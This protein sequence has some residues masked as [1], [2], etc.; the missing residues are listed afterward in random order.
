[1]LHVYKKLWDYEPARQFVL[2]PI[3]I[4]Q[5]PS[6]EK[7][8]E[9]EQFE[10]LVD[11]IQDTIPHTSAADLAP[12]TPLLV[13]NFLHGW[14]SGTP[15]Q[16]L[17]ESYQ[18]ALTQA[19]LVC[20]QAGVVF[21]DLRPANI[22]WKENADSTVSIKLI[23]F[24]HVYTAGYAIDIDLVKAHSEDKFHRYDVSTYDNKKKHYFASVKTNYF[25]VNQI[26]AYLHEFADHDDD[27]AYTFGKFCK[28][29]WRVHCSGYIVMGTVVRTCVWITFSS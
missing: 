11:R 1:M 13:Y 16:D 7:S 28:S 15:R 23:D 12:F 4:T 19:V 9:K 22:M 21:T 25:A 8:K 27:D 18:N 5:L 6:K 2:F 3:G 29:L 17:F 26:T 20:T 10:A 14:T 24:E